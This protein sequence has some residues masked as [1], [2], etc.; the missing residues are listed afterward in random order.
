MDETVA[1][2]SNS[3]STDARYYRFGLCGLTSGG[4]TCLLAAMSLPRVAHPR[5]LTATL[6][7]VSKAAEQHLKDGWQWVDKARDALRAELVPAPNPHTGRLTLRYKL[8]DGQQSEAFVELVDYSGELLDSRLSQSE[9]AGQLRRYLAEVDGFL[10]IAEHPRPGEKSSELAGYLLHLKEALALHREE[11][12]GRGNAPSAPIAFLVNK[13]DRSGPLARSQDAHDVESARL[14]TFLHAEPA[15]PHA[16]LLAELRAASSGGCRAFPVSAFGEAVRE[17]GEKPGEF[18]EKPAC[19]APELP[20]FGLEEPFLWLVEQRDRRDADEIEA[21]SCEPDLWWNVW[22]AFWCR[23]K[24]HQI[25]ARMS[26]ASPESSRLLRVRRRLRVRFASHLA[27]L[28][29][30]WLGIELSSDAIGLRHARSAMANPADSGGWIRA[31]T[32]FTD[33]AE[34]RPWSHLL[35]HK[36]FL[37][38]S[39]AATELQSARAQR[40]E[41]SWAAVM[42]PADDT[43]RAAL[44]R[45]YVDQFP[46]GTHRADALQFLADAEIRQKRDR[47]R[48]QFETLTARIESIAKEVAQVEKNKQPDFQ[49]ASSK[50]Q[51]LLRD[52]QNVQGVEIADAALAKQWQSIIAGIG[53][54]EAKIQG[55]L[56]AGQSRKTYYDLIERKEW[57]KAG[58]YL[59]GLAVNEFPELRDH[60]RTN[61][62][63]QVEVRVRAIVGNGA[64]WQKGLNELNSFRTVQIRALLPDDADKRFA[65]LERQI[66]DDG[67]RWL[68]AQCNSSAGSAPFAKYV[69]SAPLKTMKSVA[70]GWLHFHE[71]REKPNTFRVGVAKVSWGANARNA[72]TLWDTE[73]SISIASCT[74]AP[75]VT[76]FWSDRKSA[77]TCDPKDN[78]VE[79]RDILARQVQNVEIKV[80]DVDRPDGNDYFGGVKGS[81][82]L[83][84][85]DGAT[86]DLTDADYGPNSVTFSV[87]VLDR[88][89][90]RKFAKPP[91]PPW[92][93]AK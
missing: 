59:A 58:R 28:T 89:D 60:F 50:L 17:P 49:S 44:A 29:L 88:G 27:L 78:A 1:T 57:E 93:A 74:V 53:T 40:D 51:Q 71:L 25:A 43:T 68:Y 90:W 81:W 7:P 85:L 48:V 69:E 6:L 10:F 13:W 66:N 38:K 54:L 82:L 64:D 55:Q 12:R 84:D 91:L 75:R 47:L 4:K 3:T 31:E 18:T 41:K 16:G 39:N 22:R 23:Q 35:H 67:D 76:A 9:L 14:D 70:D 80:W 42:T 20:S 65:E 36:F 72:D 37:S 34:S 19:V 46:Q 87:E 33:Y 73:N 21:S 92:E 15:P 61:I 62:V 30:L 77:W 24:A 63:S 83:E 11:A 86:H 45:D 2:P 56:T 52:A 32:W 5:G 8:T 26:H 79:V